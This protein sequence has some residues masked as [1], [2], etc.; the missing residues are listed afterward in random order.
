MST[1][2][3]NSDGILQEQHKMF[4]QLV[5]I[6]AGQEAFLQSERIDHMLYSQIP[7]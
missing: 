5:Q 6:L 2:T 1:D 4:M 3:E 7:L